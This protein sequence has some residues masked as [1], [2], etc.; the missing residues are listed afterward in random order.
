MTT[1]TSASATATQQIERSGLFNSSM[2]TDASFANPSQI[3]SD[4]STKRGIKHQQ[5]GILNVDLQAKSIRDSFVKTASEIQATQA[6]FFGSARGFSEAARQAN[7]DGNDERQTEA[8]FENVYIIPE[9]HIQKAQAVCERLEYYLSD[10]K[11]EWLVQLDASS[12]PK[13]NQDRAI[14]PCTAYLL[15]NM[16]LLYIDNDGALKYAPLCLDQSTPSRP[17]IVKLS[18]KGVKMEFLP[19]Q[20]SN[21]IVNATETMAVIVGS[22]DAICVSLQPII[23]SNDLIART[24][25]LLEAQYLESSSQ[26]ARSTIL[27]ASCHPHVTH[28][29]YILKD[30]NSFT[31]YDLKHPAKSEKFN[32]DEHMRTFS[33]VSYGSEFDR[34]V[35]FAITTERAT[36]AYYSVFFVTQ[37]CQIFWIYPLTSHLMQS[38]EATEKRNLEKHVRDWLPTTEP[39]QKE[40][41]MSYL[42]MLESPSETSHCGY[43]SLQ[44]ALHDPTTQDEANKATSIAVFEFYGKGPLFM[45]GTSN[46]TVYEVLLET[47]DT[48]TWTLGEDAPFKISKSHRLQEWEDNSISF[49]PSHHF[50]PSCAIVTKKEMFIA[51]I[52]YDGVTYQR[53]YVPTDDVQALQYISR[54]DL[55]VGWLLFAGFAHFESLFS[56]E[57]QF[58]GFIPGAPLEL[59]LK[60]LNS[61]PLLPRVDASNLQGI[62]N[63]T[64]YYRKIEKRM[65]FLK[66]YEIILDQRSREHFALSKSLAKERDDLHAELE[67]LVAGFKLANERLDEIVRLKDECDTIQDDAENANR[68]TAEVRSKQRNTEKLDRMC[69]ALEELCRVEGSSSQGHH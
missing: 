33:K 48:K 51:K 15:K 28:L 8:W 68:E 37:N 41:L 34:V 45:V 56:E 11:K 57:R 44:D 50:D 54:D 6:P 21:L 22:T 7:V 58:L 14:R 27:Q 63:T 39:S 47:S 24:D 20:A 46:T 65:N 66:Q 32:L 30:D 36:L 19:F 59:S 52:S 12:G 49:Y 38:A 55:P 40:K 60:D 1:A 2:K 26:E 18:L 29:V 35:A 53:T 4:I 3:Q 23:R 25:I 67:S 17:S 13:G 62:E 69:K 64:A 9:K 5:S 42:R 16:D 31:C 61:L 10:V 43:I